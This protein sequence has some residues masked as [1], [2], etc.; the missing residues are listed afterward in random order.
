MIWKQHEFIL[1]LNIQGLSHLVGGVRTPID[2][3]YPPKNDK[4]V[5][6]KLLSKV[7]ENSGMSRV[8][9][10]INTAFIKA[11]P[12]LVDLAKKI[13]KEMSEHISTEQVGHSRIQ[14]NIA[15][16][17]WQVLAHIWFFVQMI[18]HPLQSS[19]ATLLSFQQVH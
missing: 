2:S 1:V 6:Q 17:A 7:A 9:G 3:A 13:R 5:I 15:T 14:G 4:F 18:D 11:N 8:R 10:F 12:K 16:P 19:V